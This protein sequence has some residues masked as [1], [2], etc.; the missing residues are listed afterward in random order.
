MFLCKR[1]NE[2]FVK[3]V[4]NLF[5]VK[6][7]KLFYQENQICFYFYFYILCKRN[8]NKKDFLKEDP[9]SYD[10]FITHASCMSAN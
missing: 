9:H 5:C 10:E 3:K 6:L 2:I 4:S 8:N 1:K 7:K